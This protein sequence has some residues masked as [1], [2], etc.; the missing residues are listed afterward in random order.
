MP[1]WEY[2]IISLNTTSEQEEVLNSLG[3]D[4]WELISVQNHFTAVEELGETRAYLKRE[5]VHQATTN[6]TVGESPIDTLQPHLPRSTIGD[7]IT[8]RIPA[9]SDPEVDGWVDTGLDL[10][11]DSTGIS[12]SSD[13]TIQESSGE[14]VSPEGSA[15]HMAFNNAVGLR[16]PAGCL[17]AK[18]G[19]HGTVEP[20]YYSGFL[21]LEEKGRIYMTVNDE[22]YENNEGEFTVSITVL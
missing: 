18:V 19:E 8:L 16:L 12:I 21:A 11:E 4:R 13:G 15:E 17:V 1:T 22:S 9:Y 20:I 7:H 14:I 6:E 3:M 10:S 2:K 5:R